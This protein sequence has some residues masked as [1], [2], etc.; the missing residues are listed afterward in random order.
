M[1]I[2]EEEDELFSVLRNGTKIPIV[3]EKRKIV[4]DNWVVVEMASE[5]KLINDSLLSDMMKG[6]REV[7]T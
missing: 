6:R 5:G 1:T 7:W 2:I 4:G 3:D